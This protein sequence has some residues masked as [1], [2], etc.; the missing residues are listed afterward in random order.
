[1][2]I[3]V[4]T[5]TAT[6]LIAIATAMQRL[7]ANSIAVMVIA[8]LINCLLIITIKVVSVAITK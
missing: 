1:M 8:R 6:M 3:V 7:Q 4:V 5:T 2:Q